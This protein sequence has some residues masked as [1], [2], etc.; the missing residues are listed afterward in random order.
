[1][2]SIIFN[3]SCKHIY[4]IFVSNLYRDCCTLTIIII[5]IVIMMT[6][7]LT[8]TCTVGVDGNNVEVSFL[9]TNVLDD[10]VM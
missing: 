8:I 7:L 2:C 10:F 9:V 4:V 6:Y 1:M 3:Y 5:L